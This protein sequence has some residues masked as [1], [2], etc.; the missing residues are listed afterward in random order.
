[1]SLRRLPSCSS[2]FH[3][4][5]GKQ[6][7]CVANTLGFALVSLKPGAFA[8]GTGSLNSLSGPGTTFFFCADVWGYV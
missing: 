5:C 4:V 6:S 3:C 7:G 1:M 2:H 8:V